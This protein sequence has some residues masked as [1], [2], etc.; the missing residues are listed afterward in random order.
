MISSRTCHTSVRSTLPASITTSCCLI[1]HFVATCPS[2]CNGFPRRLPSNLIPTACGTR[3]PFVAALAEDDNTLRK[4]VAAAASQPAQL[5]KLLESVRLDELMAA[6]SCVRDAAFPQ[7]ITTFSPKVFIPLTRLCR[8]SCGYCTF[9]QPPQP[10][11][12]AYMTIEEVLEV[13]AAGVA[14][15]CYEALFTLGECERRFFERKAL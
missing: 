9:A 6:A 10:G 11:R 15:G 7:G 13:A 1:R 3:T 4:L 5:L 8:D 14:L 2:S 12:R